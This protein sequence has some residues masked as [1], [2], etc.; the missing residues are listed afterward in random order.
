MKQGKITQHLKIA[1]IIGLLL[2]LLIGLVSLSAWYTQY[3]QVNY[4]IEDYFPKT[5]AA[6]KLEDKFNVFFNDL[7]RFYYL[8]NNLNRQ[9]MFKNLKHQLNE[10]ETLSSLLFEQKKRSTI[11]QYLNDLIQLTTQIDNNLSNNFLILQQK[12]TLLTKIQWLNDDF[13]NEII[14]QIQE[15][16]W[17]NNYFLKHSSLLNEKNQAKSENELFYL[18]Q[19]ADKE[20]QIRTELVQFLYNLYPNQTTILQDYAYLKQLITALIQAPSHIIKNPSIV[21][22]QQMF[23]DLYQMIEPHHELDNLVQEITHY[24]TE[25]KNI[26]SQK[27]D[28]VAKTQEMIKQELNETR[29]SFTRLNENLKQQTK[30]SGVIIISS[31]LIFLILIALFNQYYVKRRLSYRF[32]QLIY[33]IENLNLGRINQ[34][35]NVSGKDELTEI[36]LLLNNHIQ[37]LQEREKIEKDLQETQNELLQAA[38]MAVVGQTMTTLAHEINQ[39][40]NA[41]SIYLFTLKKRLEQQ[42]DKQS[43][44]D[45]EKIEKLI[46]RIANIIKALRQFAKNEISSTPHQVVSLKQ[47]LTEAW[48]VLELRHKPLNAE[49]QIKGDVCLLINPILLE[50][51]FVNI[52]SNALEAGQAIPIIQVDVVCYQD[53]TCVFI[54]DNGSGWQTDNADKLLQPFFTTKSVGLG[55][56]LTICQR[57]MQQFGG[58]LAIASSLSKS[59]VVILEFLH[60]GEEKC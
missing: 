16:N 10:I 33:A 4:I 15:L 43:Y 57:I 17:Q 21:P 46:E 6:L 48:N 36:G 22:L 7:E 32:S 50:Q 12:Q 27:N 28:I 59:A 44:L 5:N 52:L 24:Q 1:S 13:N 51:V 39:P 45:I 49:L 58:K 40:L 11:K 30:I 60:S 23:N 47:S 31:L 29:G 2:T 42:K 41:I 19:L 55:L 56:G 18:Y 9:V 25:L 54:E 34:P 38:K 37:I 14:S 26:Q 53:K 20:E 3:R 8:Q 35:I